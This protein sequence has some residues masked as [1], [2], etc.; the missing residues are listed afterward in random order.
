M[1]GV[2]R[3]LQMPPTQVC[4]LEQACP[5]VPQL[6]ASVL[7]LVQ[8]P[9]H[10][11]RPPAQQTET[12]APFRQLAPAPQHVPLQGGLPV[13]VQIQMPLLLGPL[14]AGQTQLPCAQT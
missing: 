9:L 14:S 3:S 11:L 8:L 4:P 2:H 7:V 13:A 12:Q 5:H 10:R 1:P 6:A